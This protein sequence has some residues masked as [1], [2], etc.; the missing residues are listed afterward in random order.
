MKLTNRSAIART[1]TKPSNMPTFLLAALLTVAMLHTLSAVSFPQAEFLLATLKVVIFGTLTLSKASSALSPKETGVLQEV[2]LD[3]RTVFTKLQLEP[4]IVEYA[5]CRD[6]F[7]IYPPDPKSPDDP[8][9]CFC[10]Y[11]ETDKASC[12][13]ALVQEKCLAPSKKGGGTRIVFEPFRS[14]PFRSMK[15]W[16]AELFMRQEIEQSLEKSWETSASGTH[17]CADVM[18]ASCIRQFIGPD[19]QTLFSVQEHGAVHLVF[20]LFVDWFNPHGNKK[21]GKS[22]SIGAVYMAC[23]N[24][25]PH[26]RFRPENI[27][28]AGLIPGPK[29]PQVHEINHLLRPLVDE[30][31]QLW[32]RGIHLSRTVRR[33]TGRLVRAAVIPLVCDLP[34]LRK[35]AG[36][37]HYA[38]S[39]FCSFC[40]LQR[41]D[42]SNAERESWPP[43]RSK[44]EHITIAHQWKEA[45]T[46]SSRRKI[47]DEHGVR[48]SELLRLEYWDPTRFA[49][50]D[51]MHNLF[52]GELKHH[53]M[54]VFGLDTV[55]EKRPRVLTSHTPEE[56]KS[57][58]EG[59][60]SA[61]CHPN[62]SV[63]TLCKARREYLLAVAQVNGITVGKES[64]KRQIAEVLL[65]WVRL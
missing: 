60:R 34:A 36:F 40:R 21:A 4:G 25:P 56:Q 58:L 14:Y 24:L 6:C 64:T 13:K 41:Q 39:N 54:Q 3:M 10:T 50:V 49:L 1:F 55:G 26:L 20:S 65:K 53:C 31:F 27:Y 5:V 52:L 62:P 7:A 46:E 15:T 19:G 63:T 12:G 33:E 57:Y 35:T 37:A 17:T 61:L 42:M 47:F 29:E 38:S 22:H 23:L 11:S 51:T 32:H 9:P 43:S 44:E 30:L 59:I 45:K 8:Y 16:L 48:W 18:D 2:P 28:L